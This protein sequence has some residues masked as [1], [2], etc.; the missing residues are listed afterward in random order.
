MTATKQ[1]RRQQAAPAQ[2]VDVVEDFDYSNHSDSYNQAFK[3]WRKDE[4]NDYVFRCKRG[5]EVVYVEGKGYS[6]SDPAAEERSAMARI[7]VVIGVAMLCYLLIENLLSVVLMGVFHLIGIDVNYTYSDNTLYGNQTAVLLILMAES[8]LK[9]LVP[10]LIF[11]RFFRMPRSVSAQLRPYV[12]AEM[13]SS[14]FITIAAFSVSNIWLLFSSVNII[15]YS[16]LGNAY[17][18]V[19][20]MSPAYQII[21]MLYELLIVTALTEIM[22]H[23]EVFHV[24]RQFGDWYA[25][26]VTSMLAVCAAH[27]PVTVLMEFVVSVIAGCAVLRSGS[28]LS[29]IFN[30]IACRVILLV[31]FLMEIQPSHRM[32]IYRPWFLVGLLMVGLVGMVLFTKPARKRCGLVTQKHYLSPRQ[33]LVVLQRSGPLAI[34]FGLCLVL[35]VIEVVF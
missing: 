14:F 17:Y 13:L 20:Y 5:T 35:M 9:Y 23:G 29:A 7:N 6:A 25:V 16:A 33:R 11:H 27:S 24:L 18:A 26:A 30:R 3:A 4:K 8:L 12:P 31:L 34:T 28:L 10:I 2:S 1:E 19:S 15:S 22:L 32:Y 21:Y